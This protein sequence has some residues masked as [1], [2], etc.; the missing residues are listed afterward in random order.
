MWFGNL[1]TMEWWDDLWLNEGFARFMEH[2]IL[3]KIRPEFRIMDKYLRQVHHLAIHSDRDL[4][5]THPVQVAVPEPDQLQ[6]IFDT[7][8]YAKGSAICR[9]LYAY[10]GDDTLF[11]RCLKAYMEKFAYG[12]ATTRDLLSVFDEVS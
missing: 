4:G 9:M 12:S 3:E 8:S 5:N 1:V 11:F 7:I 6:S 10:I 2:Y